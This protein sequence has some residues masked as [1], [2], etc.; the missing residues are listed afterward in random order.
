[1]LGQHEVV[2]VSHKGWSGLKNGDLLRVAKQSS[3][4]V[5]VTGDRTLKYEQNLSGR[6]LAIVVLSSIELPIL[7]KHLPAIIAAIESAVP[8]T[9]QSID[10]VLANHLRQIVDWREVPGLGMLRIAIE[11]R[12][13]LETPALLIES[14]TWKHA[15]LHSRN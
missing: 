8:G 15:L 9:L 13:Q 1:M 11:A 6:Q 3:I 7:R 14:A 5:F 4:Q 12:R 2:T 10:C